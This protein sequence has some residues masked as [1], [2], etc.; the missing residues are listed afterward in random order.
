MGFDSQFLWNLNY[1]AA[2]KSYSYLLGGKW[3]SVL[4]PVPRFPMP[5]LPYVRYSVKR[6]Q[7]KNIY[8]I[9]ILPILPSFQHKS[10]LI[11]K[12]GNVVRVDTTLIL[13]GIYLLYSHHFSPTYHKPLTNTLKKYKMIG[14]YRTRDRSEVITKLKNIF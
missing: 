10:A 13:L 8:L 11:T 4:I 1:Q 3:Q 2:T 5:T 9:R 6:K 12:C 14:S 7:A